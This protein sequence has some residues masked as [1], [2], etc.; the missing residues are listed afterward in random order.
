[1]KKTLCALTALSI[2]ASFS[3]FAKDK[4]NIYLSYCSN[5]GKGVDFSFQS[6]VND[7][8]SSV[9]RELGGYFGYCAN[10][11]DE[12]SYSFTSCVNSGFSEAARLLDNK[13]FLQSCFNFNQKELDFSFISCVNSNYNEISRAIGQKQ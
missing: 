2:L 10:Y 1:M 8:F 12:V 7:N 6:C 13:V 5:Y 9:G 3:A 11:G 4:N